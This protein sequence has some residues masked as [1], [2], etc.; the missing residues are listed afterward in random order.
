MSDIIPWTNYT[1]IISQRTLSRENG[2]FPK[3]IQKRHAKV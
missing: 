3:H 1:E 2:L